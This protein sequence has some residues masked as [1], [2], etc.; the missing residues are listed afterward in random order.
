MPGQSNLRLPSAS[1]L[2]S[3][4]TLARAA[5]LLDFDGTLVEIAE[6]PDAVRVPDTLPPLLLRLAEALGGAVA[7]V[8]G[9]PMRDLDA[10][11]PVP[12]AKAAE[13][14]AVL[15]PDPA[16]P[17][18]LLDLPDPP[19]DWLARARPWVAQ[20]PGALIETKGHGFV[21]HFRQAGPDA[22][23]AARALL[24]A[25]IAEVPDRFD[26]LE[27]S[28]AWEIR[29]RGASKATAVRALMARSPFAGRLPIFI[30][31]DITDEDGMAAC[32]DL[33]GEGLRLQEAFGSPAA[34]RTWLAEAVAASG[35]DQGKR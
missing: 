5:L 10:L 12:I 31:D 20:H 28:M 17:A 33:G 3:L 34:L 25:L 24:S 26:L 15:R 21:L 11:L 29:P 30:G 18:I 16:A 35:P 1:A 22:G 23:I 14:G 19:A 27:A 32:R 7:V 8:S 13:H 2:A 6:R 9:R 4:P